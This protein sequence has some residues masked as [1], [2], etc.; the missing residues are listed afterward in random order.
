MAGIV[1]KIDAAGQG[2]WRLTVEIKNLGDI[3]ASVEAPLTNR[4]SAIPFCRRSIPAGSRSL[5][6]V[7]T[8]MASAFWPTAGG[9]SGAICVT[10]RISP[11]TQTAARITN[12]TMTSRALSVL[13]RFTACGPVR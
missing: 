13:F 5:P 7:S 12:R 11:P 4:R 6:P 1:S 10:K 9:V 2:R 3:D 8:T